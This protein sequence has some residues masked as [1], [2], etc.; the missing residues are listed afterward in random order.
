MKKFFTLIA[1]LLLV[2]SGAFAQT[3]WTN[4]TPNGNFEGEQ[5]PLWSSFWCHDWRTPEQ[6]GEINPESKSLL[7]QT[8]RTQ[9]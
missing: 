9:N 2:S 6:V 3:K 8:T 1:G 4:V 7:I 5:D